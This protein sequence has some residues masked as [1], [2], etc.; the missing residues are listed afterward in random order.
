MDF[1]IK[2]HK[3]SLIN[4]DDSDE[5]GANTDDTPRKDDYENKKG[6]TLNPSNP[7]SV[8]DQFGDS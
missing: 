2:Y 6:A 7:N 4:L 3:K 1:G 5:D 8:R